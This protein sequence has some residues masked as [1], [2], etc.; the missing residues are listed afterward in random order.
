MYIEDL[1]AVLAN[2]FAIKIKSQYHKSVISSLY[3]TNS[4]G[5][6]FTEKQKNFALFILRQYVSELNGELNVDVTQYLTAPTL[7]YPLRSPATMNKTISIEPHH[8]LGRAIFVKFPYNEDII[9]DIKTAQYYGACFWEADSK[10]WVSHLSEAN[11]MVAKLVGSKYGFEMSHEFREIAASITEVLNSFENYVPMVS[12]QN[13]IPVYR[14]APD[15]LPPLDTN[16]CI[17]AAFQARL[18]GVSTW[19]SKFEK[20]I[21]N[22][23]GDELIKKFLKDAELSVPYDIN[24]TRY[25]FD[26]VCKILAHTFPTIVVIPGGTELEKTRVCVQAL[27]RFGVDH[28]DMSVMFRLPSKTNAEFNHFVKDNS[29]N[30]AIRKNT[31]VVFISGKLPKPVLSSGIQFNSVVNMGWLNRWPQRYIKLIVGKCPNIINYRD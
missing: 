7:R 4:S 21:N 12:Y 16:D 31:K 5:S 15:T 1:I 3:A 11:I 8:L 6:G 24:G 9:N 25:P 17:S 13:G 10:A 14:N 26:S 29:L 27:E 19:D 28:K 18:S 2:N 30:S 23:N 20:A 22:Q